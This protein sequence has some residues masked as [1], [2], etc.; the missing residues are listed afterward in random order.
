MAHFAVENRE[1]RR[2]TQGSTGNEKEICIATN[3]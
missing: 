3:K 2:K 1:N